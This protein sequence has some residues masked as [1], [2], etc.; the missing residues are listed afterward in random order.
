MRR[1]LQNHALELEFGVAPE[2]HG[3]QTPRLKGISNLE[4]ERFA[5]EIR[6]EEAAAT[7]VPVLPES[8][9]KLEKEV[10]NFDPLAAYDR[11]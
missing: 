3:L 5:D 9:G 6:A 11:M 8:I 7:A 4:Y 2:Q 10:S 1:D